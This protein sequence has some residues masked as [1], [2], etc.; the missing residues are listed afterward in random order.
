MQ[1]KLDNPGQWIRQWKKFSQGLAERPAL[2]DEPVF[3]FDG[4]AWHGLP[5]DPR[6]LISQYLQPGDE[7]L[8]F[9][10]CPIGM[11]T[12]D[13]FI[14]H[15]GCRQLTCQQAQ[16]LSPAEY[17]YF[18]GLRRDWDNENCDDLLGVQIVPHT[19]R[20]EE[21]DVL[22]G[23]SIDWWVTSACLA[24][25]MDLHVQ[26]RQELQDQGRW[27]EWQDHPDITVRCISGSDPEFYARIERVWYA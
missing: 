17:L 10:H 24:L 9:G 27:V 8:C 26:R 12:E 6:R 25:P 3:E 14:D 15:G 19:E 1:L 23:D 7:V 4:R 18:D 22:F 21:R 20:N 16:Q 2:Y 5:L 13:A 11:I